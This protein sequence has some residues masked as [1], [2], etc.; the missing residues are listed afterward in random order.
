VTRGGKPG[1]PRAD[2]ARPARMP[3]YAGSH[4]P[5]ACWQVPIASQ[6]LAERAAGPVNQSAS[7]VPGGRFTDLAACCRRPMPGCLPAEIKAIPA[8]QPATPLRVRLLPG[9]EDE[10]TER[11]TGQQVQRGGGHSHAAIADRMAEY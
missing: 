3:G 6:W 5:T 7:V 11:D 10:G 8:E 1:R 9:D 4:P 2:G